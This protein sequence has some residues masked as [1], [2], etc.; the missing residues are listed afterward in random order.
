M[1]EDLN[2]IEDWTRLFNQYKKS[3]S[4]ENSIQKMWTDWNVRSNPYLKLLPNIDSLIFAISTFKPNRATGAAIANTV[5]TIT[6]SDAPVYDTLSNS[7]NN[8]T[9][10][11]CATWR[12]WHEAL[13]KHYNSTKKANAI[14]E[15]AWSHPDNECYV[16]GILLCPGTSHCRY[17]CSFVEYFASKEIEIGNILSNTT[18]DLSNVISNIVEAAESTT[19]TVKTVAPLVTTGLIIYGGNR[20]YQAINE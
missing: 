3:F 8:I 5:E 13:E 9:P 7:W 1:R 14:W 6:W 18:C 17:D 15:V 20:I 19:N 10:W 11:N 2:T 16:T 4:F 12:Y